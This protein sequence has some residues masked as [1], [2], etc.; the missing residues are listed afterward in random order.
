MALFRFV[1]MGSPQQPV[2]EVDGVH[3][4]AELHHVIARGRFVEGRLVPEYCE[5]VTCGALIAT[6]RIQMVMEVE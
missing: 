1:V 3:T 4:I 2:M 5:G 6:S